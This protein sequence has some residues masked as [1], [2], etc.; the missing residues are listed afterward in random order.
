MQNFWEEN[1]YFK[2]N[3]L[4][5][6]IILL[7]T[8]LPYLCESNIIFLIDALNN[9]RAH[10]NKIIL[11]IS[12]I[13]DIDPLGSIVLVKEIEKI[14]LAG[15]EVKLIVSEEKPRIYFSN[16]DPITN[17][18]LYLDLKSALKNSVN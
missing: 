12:Q 15:G 6:D 5:Q 1:K 4:N 16:G 14:K 9:I 7:S 11:D 2:A 18:D 8:K 3:E 13:D 10:H 17:M